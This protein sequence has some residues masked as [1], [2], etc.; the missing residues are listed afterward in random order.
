MTPVEFSNCKGSREGTVHINPDH[1]VTVCDHRG[2]W[3][4]MT[5]ADGQRIYVE[6]E[7]ADVLTALNP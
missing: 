3:V 7:V 4:E 5:L 1:V 2:G 6:D